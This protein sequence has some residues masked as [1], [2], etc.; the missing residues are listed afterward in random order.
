MGAIDFDAVVVGCGPAGNTVAFRLARGGARVLMLER[1]ALP[2]HKVCGGGLS[3]KTLEELP[4]PVAPVIE[5]E[6]TSATIAYRGR[7]PIELARPGIGAMVQRH[8]FDAFMTEAAVGAGAMLWEACAFDGFADRPDA[9]EVR[10]G[11]GP[12]TARV[13]VGADGV[14]SGVRRQLYPGRRVRTVPAIE[15]LVR[16]R[17]GMLELLGDACV[18]DLGAIP[19]GYAWIFPKRDHF[20]VGL[21]RFRKRADNLAMK[22]LLADFIAGS[23]LLRDPLAVETKALSIPVKAVSARLARGRVV[24]VGDAAG[25]GEAFYGEGIYDAVRSANLA[26]AAIL[27]SLDGGGQ[28]AEYD[29]AMRALRRSLA[30]SRATAALFYLSPRLGFERGVRN[31]RVSRLFAGVIDGSVSPARCFWSFLLLAPHWLVAPRTAAVASP[32][33][34]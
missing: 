11:R 30:Y 3:R 2:R 6:I 29:R 7:T 33:F 15:A 25:V 13:L 4:Y 28:L 9:I 27:A 20:N 17:A 14:Q 26:A 24:L 21:Y 34:D 32:L 19:A 5:K 8:R 23:K 12:V 1:E 16:P 10:T 22:Q 31:P 18:F